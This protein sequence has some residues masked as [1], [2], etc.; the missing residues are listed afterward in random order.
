MLGL[1]NVG[2]L[3]TILILAPLTFAGVQLGVWLNGRFSDR[4]FI[5]V[6]Y[7]L[8]FWTGLELVTGVSVI[9]LLF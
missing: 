9:H 3:S 5:Y 7:A 8:L 6:I 2:N 4:W 1:L